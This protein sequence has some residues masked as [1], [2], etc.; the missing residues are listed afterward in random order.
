MDNQ[1][2]D[3]QKGIEEIFEKYFNTFPY[4]EM[5]MNKFKLKKAI[6][7]GDLFTKSDV[8][9]KEIEAKI[10]AITEAMDT[11]VMSY[12]HIDPNGRLEKQMKFLLDAF[13]D[14]RSEFEAQLTE[15]KDYEQLNSKGS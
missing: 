13:R 11:L 9:R 14:L 4:E 8:E 5:V 3:K 6:T 2:Q 7:N 12:P 1:N 15:L 10:E